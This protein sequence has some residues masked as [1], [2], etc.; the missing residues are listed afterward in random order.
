MEELNRKQLF[1]SIGLSEETAY[2]T[3]KNAVLSSYLQ[4]CI[5]AVS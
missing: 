2:E 3:V 1:K 4:T 5:D